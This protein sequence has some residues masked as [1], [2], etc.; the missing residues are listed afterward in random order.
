MS[1]WYIGTIS[2]HTDFTKLPL[3]VTRIRESSNVRKFAFFY[4][5]FFTANS[6]F[7]WLLL[8]MRVVGR[9]LFQFLTNFNRQK[10]RVNEQTFLSSELI[11]RTILKGERRLFFIPVL[12]RLRLNEQCKYQKAS[13]F[14]LCRFT[15]DNAQ[16][17]DFSLPHVYQHRV[18]TAAVVMMRETENFESIH[19]R[20]RVTFSVLGGV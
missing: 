19:L 9:K 1:D 14:I 6:R 10:F 11:F 5:F 2:H 4:Q 8:C 20:A 3:P 7:V 18:N 13:N 16:F 12:L 17:D 15:N